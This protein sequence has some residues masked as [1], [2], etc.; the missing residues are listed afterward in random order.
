MIIERL[1]KGI[2]KKRGYSGLEEESIILG[3]LNQLE[4]KK[5][6]VDIAAQNGINMSNTY[7]LYKAGYTGLAVECD[8]KFFA[9]LANSYKDFE[10]VMLSKIYVY[11]ENV[12][13]LLEAHQIPYDFGFL[14]F[15]IDGYDHFVLNELL[16]KYRP[17]L[18]CAEINEKIPYPIKFTVKYDRAHVWDKTHFYGQ[19]ISQLYILCEKYNYDLVDLHYNN[20]FL[21]AKEKN[22]KFLKLHPETAYLN[23]YKNQSDRLQKFP[24]NKDLDAALHMPPQEALKFMNDYF[25][26]YVGKYEASI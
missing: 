21:I 19:S 3:Y 10:N 1:K 16:A 22:N 4:H 12:I 25:K 18:I 23:G 11:P 15:D 7:S 5:I 24:W 2:S 26:N 20:A 9:S 14:S 13:Q 8:S 6:A 17:S